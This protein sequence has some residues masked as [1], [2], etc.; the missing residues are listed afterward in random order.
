L[1][2]WAKA[3]EFF[4]TVIS[5]PAVMASAIMVESYKKLVLASLIHKGEVGNLP[6]VTNPSVIR[7]IKQLCVPYEELSTAFTTNSFEDLTKSVD[8]NL[9]PFV[10]DANLGLVGQVKSSLAHKLI[11]NITQTHVT[12]T[13]PGL[14]EQTEFAD[15]S[16]AEKHILKMVEC[17]G[18][19]AKIDQQL[20]YV[21]FGNIQEYNSDATVKYLNQHIYNT[22]SVH[23]QVSSLDRSIEKSDKYVQK[24]LQSDKF[25]GK[26]SETGDKI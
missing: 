17:S 20:G 9:E 3:I 24:M 1:K 11:R 5:A 18:F 8:N 13:I 21:S 26:D 14:L 7:V 22:I 25:S 19:S 10:K 16:E 12:I 23:V 4:E 2:Q 6:K 15:Q